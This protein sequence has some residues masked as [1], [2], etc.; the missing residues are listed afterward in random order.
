M[1][2]KKKHRPTDETL[3]WKERLRLYRKSRIPVV[4]LML[5]G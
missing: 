1:K 5:F 3:S 4:M 2:Q